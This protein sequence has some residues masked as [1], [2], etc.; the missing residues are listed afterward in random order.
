MRNRTILTRSTLIAVL[1]FIAAV[2]TCFAATL[3]VGQ[4][5]AIPTQ[6]GVSVPISLASGAGE[7]VAAIQF[8]ILFD[9]A[10][11][12]LASITAGP[13][14]TSAGKDINFSA[15]EPG[16]ARAII[17]GLNQNVIS[18]GTIANALFNVNRNAPGGEQSLALSGVLLSDPNGAAVPSESV[19]GR[20]N[21]EA[22]VPTGANGTRGIILVCA[23][24][25][26]AA[27]IFGGARLWCAGS[28]RQ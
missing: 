20:I 11:L 21:I 6:R 13:A 14:T 9:Y 4:N 16:R 8:D 1:S 23:V 25:V 7:Q 5:S 28:Q 19:S 10:I 3:T 26:A 18:D 2:A 12:A 15:I 17:A 24:F 27:L 22:I